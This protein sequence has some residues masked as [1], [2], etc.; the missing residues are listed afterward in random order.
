[1]KIHYEAEIEHCMKCPFKEYQVEFGGSFYACKLL[2]K[3]GAGYEAIIPD[4]G[5]KKTCPFAEK[6]A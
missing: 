3:Q 6:S 1:M 5:I 2:L 4:K